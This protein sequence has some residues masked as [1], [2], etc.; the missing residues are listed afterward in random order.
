VL[1]IWLPLIGGLVLLKAGGELPVRGAVQ[2][3]AGLGVS[4]LVTGLTPFGFPA[5]R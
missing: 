4:P 3:A 2:V 5:T 1:A